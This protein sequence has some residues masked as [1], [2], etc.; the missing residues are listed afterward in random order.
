M[1]EQIFS[2]SGTF[3]S[4]L[5]LRFVNGFPC[6]TYFEKV[7]GDD[8]TIST[9]TVTDLGIVL[10]KDNI[11]VISKDGVRHFDTLTKQFGELSEVDHTEALQKL[12]KLNAEREQ[13]RFL[14]LPAD[15]FTA[16]NAII[17]DKKTTEAE[18]TRLR[19]VLLSSQRMTNRQIARTVK[20]NPKDVGR[21]IRA[22]R[23]GGIGALI[24]SYTKN[25]QAADKNPDNVVEAIIA[26]K[27]EDNAAAQQNIEN[28]EVLANQG[29]EPTIEA[30]SED[31]AAAQQNVENAK[32]L[33]N[34]G[35]E[36]TIAA[37]SE[38]NAAAQQNI[39]NA[40]VLAN[41]GG[42]PT[43]EAKSDTLFKPENNADH[44]TPQSNDLISKGK[45]GL[46]VSITVNVTDI[47][48]NE[49]VYSDTVQIENI[50]R[51]DYSSPRTF[52]NYLSGLANSF[53]QAFRAANKKCF[54][55]V[56]CYLGTKTH[57]NE[58]MVLQ[59]FETFNGLFLIYIPKDLKKKLV[60]TEKLWDPRLLELIINAIAFMS[61]RR[62]TN[63]LNKALQRG[64]D[65]EINFRTIH[66]KCLK[67]GEDM[68]E[69]IETT[70]DTTLKEYGL[71]ASTFT[72]KK[73]KDE[74]T[75]VI[76]P[77]FDKEDAEK[78][79]KIIVERIEKYNNKQE[80]DDFK[81]DFNTLLNTP[82][83]SMKNTIILTA[84]NI[85]VKEQN[86][87]H[88]RKGTE[89]KTDDVK[90]EN[91]RLNSA[92][93]T[94]FSSVGTINIVQESMEKALKTALAMMLKYKL[95]ENK[96]LLCFTDG[97]EAIN[98]EIKRVFG[99]RQ[100]RILLDWFHLQKKSR[101]FF[102]MILKGGKQNKAKN[103]GIRSRFFRLLFIGNYE[104]A[105]KLLDDIDKSMIKDNDI[106]LKFKNYL[107]RKKE[108]LYVYYL[109]KILHMI[110]AS[111]MAEK[112]NDMIIAQR[113][114]NNGT[115]WVRKG[116]NGMGLARCTFLN[117]EEHW[118]TDG[119]LDFNPKPLS[120][121]VLDMNSRYEK[122]YERITAANF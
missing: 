62:G 95:L 120:E 10:D 109:R 82:R 47:A 12:V 91:H 67:Q 99:F 29:G 59:K 45:E 50:G 19:C 48:T 24:S 5:D 87:T 35:V 90:K 79:N 80:E 75:R 51:P 100:C 102:S 112:A 23:K 28:T 36:P 31:N 78:V 6:G 118:Y 13:S 113:C 14:I 77:E 92:V 108:Y 119:R 72:I 84:D 17:A 61:Y 41:Q 32:V 46:A 34:Q 1:S 56:T 70:V 83:Y 117:G 37:K 20:C 9:I 49:K 103:L 107:N 66:K 11:T 18:A 121:K 43:I 3:F 73:V 42:E 2:K 74:M 30:K 106:L 89:D 55:F 69:Y 110:N 15:E 114:K 33:A 105:I 85:S 38:D 16:I 97:E 122:I 96:Y 8:G 93:V 60:N 94:I 21:W 22:Y 58:E 111:N 86:S 52:C 63:L 65:E 76:N 25:D 98:N 7:A 27:S 81:I 88:K 116:I 68:N 40:K 39:E 64:S 53:S 44:N 101:E 71:D 57:K 54:Q 26:A 4:E 115:S 104:K